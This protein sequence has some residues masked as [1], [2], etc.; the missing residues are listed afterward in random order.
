MHYTVI[1]HYGHLGTFEKCRKH[2]PA[3]R[4]FYISLVFSNAR[5]VLSQCN[6]RPR[7]LYLFTKTHFFVEIGQLFSPNKI[8]SF[9]TKFSKN[10]AFGSARIATPTVYIDIQFFYVSDTKAAALTTAAN[11]GSTPWSSAVNY[12]V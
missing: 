7:L 12:R 8:I 6:T 9:V 2:S 1:E 5:R 10:T 11:K 3:A 4:V